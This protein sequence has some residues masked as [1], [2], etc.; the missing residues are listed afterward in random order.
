MPHAIF[1]GLAGSGRTL[2]GGW[3]SL[4]D[5]GVVEAMFAAGFDYVGIDCQ[6]T[7]LD[8]PA[9]GRLL[10]V[11]PKGGPAALVRVPSNNAADIGKALDAG[12]DGVI[13]PM[14]N[15]PEEAAAAVAA[16]RYAPEG[17]RSFGPIRT[18][19][20]FD[21]PGLTARTGCFVMAETTIALANIERI[22]ATPGLTGVYV[23]PA[24][25]AVS[26]GLPIGRNPINPA[27]REAI[28]KIGEACQRAGLIAGGHFS[29]AEVP[30]LRELGYS[31]ITMS[32]DRA[33]IAIGAQA[34]L[35]VARGGAKSG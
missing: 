22:C 21:I 17:V 5:V 16:C 10:H 23:G 33:Y 7:L 1:E 11:V 26:M 25:L 18:G 32:A 12:A 15:T 8:V 2:A 13:V 6:H 35:K 19:M 30:M 4:N 24:D 34:D 27:L 14:V 9:A 28:A 20:P 3:I 29:A 31:M